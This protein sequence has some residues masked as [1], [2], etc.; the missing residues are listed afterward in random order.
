MSAV[1]IV[2]GNDALTARRILSW[3][4]KQAEEVQ[5]QI[6]RR[7]YGEF[8]RQKNIHPKISKPAL[9]LASLVLA[10][11]DSGWSDEHAYR[12]SK[13]LSEDSAKRISERRR[14]GA[15]AYLPHREQVRSWLAKHWGKVMDMRRA[16]LSW[17]RTAAMIADEHGIRISHTTLHAYWRHWHEQAQ[18]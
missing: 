14:A 18:P 16:G 3:F 17:R 9:D 13:G 1:S 4:A 2:T 15:K 6:M 7:K 5:V 11:H 12:S 10:A 8:M